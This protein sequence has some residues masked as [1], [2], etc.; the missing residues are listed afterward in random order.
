LTDQDD[1]DSE[2]L[3]IM[4]LTPQDDADD[5]RV[6]YETSRD[7]ADGPM[8]GKNN[9]NDNGQLQNK[10]THTNV[11]PRNYHVSTFAE[12]KTSLR[13]VDH[14]KRSSCLQDELTSSHKQTHGPRMTVVT[15]SHHA[16]DDLR[17]CLCFFFKL[18]F[19]G[20]K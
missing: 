4:T 13:P 1:A 7:T 18:S 5:S 8:T 11:C 17:H 9:V 14:R 10:H 2:T 16:R 3:S 12:R 15:S 19:T 20:Y 6:H